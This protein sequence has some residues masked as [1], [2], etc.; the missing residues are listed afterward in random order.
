MGD[1]QRCQEENETATIFTSP[2]KKLAAPKVFP[3]SPCLPDIISQH[4]DA[5]TGST[6]TMRSESLKSAG[7]LQHPV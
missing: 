5:K 2:R 3:I 1:W 6:I 4:W 7:I